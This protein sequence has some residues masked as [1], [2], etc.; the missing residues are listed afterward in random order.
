MMEQTTVLVVR[1][2]ELALQI[3]TRAKLLYGVNLSVDQVKA[4]NRW[5]EKVNEA[6]TTLAE[7]L[8][9][10]FNDIATK[11]AKALGCSFESLADALS[12]IYEAI[13]VEEGKH[14]AHHRKNDFRAVSGGYR[15]Q[16]AKC[17]PNYRNRVIHNTRYY[18]RG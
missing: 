5:L 10:T 13:E 18:R 15:A 17:N 16:Y 4:M 6:L 7:Q 1:E 12:S 9:E 11:M 2:D 3:S 14:T 8:A